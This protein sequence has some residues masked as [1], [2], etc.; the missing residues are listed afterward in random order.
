VSEG[1]GLDGEATQRQLN[2]NV[3]PACANVPRINLGVNRERH[4]TNLGVLVTE[5]GLQVFLHRLDHG[6]SC[7]MWFLSWALQ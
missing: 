7:F 4:S 2:T 3:A 1:T 6:E 5:H